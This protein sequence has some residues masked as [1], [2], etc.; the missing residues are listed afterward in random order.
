M[1]VSCR[2]HLEPHDTQFH[3]L[4]FFHCARGASR[5]RIRRRHRSLPRGWATGVSVRSS[6]WASHK[7]THL[8]PAAFRPPKS[9]SAIFPALQRATNRKFTHKR[10]TAKTERAEKAP[11]TPR[12]GLDRL[13][14]FAFV[15]DYHRFAQTLDPPHTSLYRTSVVIN[16]VS[17]TH[18]SPLRW[19]GA[20]S[21]DESL[22]SRRQSLSDTPA[23]AARSRPASLPPS[24]R[25]RRPRRCTSRGRPPQSRA[26]CRS[27]FGG[28]RSPR[29]SPQ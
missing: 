18:I 29:G 28:S 21:F 9:P 5:R 15:T 1:D 4:Q 25:G 23:R 11:R 8:R 10:E 20:P 3:L 14:R 24:C 27:G 16:T 26:G 19:C 7:R 6:Q 13:V 12:L 2:P 17:N 22:G